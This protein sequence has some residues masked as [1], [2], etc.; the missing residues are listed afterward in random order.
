MHKQKSNA[1]S[2][3]KHQNL[4]V[5]QYLLPQEIYE[6]LTFRSYD[7]NCEF[8]MTSLRTPLHFEASLTR[9]KT[10]LGVD[11]NVLELKT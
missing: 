2:Q 11:F 7:N 3:L 9:A 6:I 8:S 10:C 1:G 5:S 4:H